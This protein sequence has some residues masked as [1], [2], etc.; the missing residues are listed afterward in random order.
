MRVKEIGLVRVDVAKAERPLSYLSFSDV[1]AIKG[2][3][4]HRSEIDKF[5]GVKQNNHYNFAGDTMAMNEE[6]IVTY[7]ALDEYMRQVIDYY[8]EELDVVRMFEQGYTEKEIAETVGLKKNEVVAMLDDIAMRIKTLNDNKYYES[9][10]TLIYW[11]KK[12]VKI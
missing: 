8:T 4:C 9:V 11:D 12:K 10:K 2:L 1:D 6:I 3:I 5:Y 7:V